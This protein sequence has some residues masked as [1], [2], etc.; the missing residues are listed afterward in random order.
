MPRKVPSPELCDMDSDKLLAINV[1]YVINTVGFPSLW[2]M[3]YTV[4]S[5]FI[6]Y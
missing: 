5:H 2:L 4:S 1:Q 6:P 3:Q